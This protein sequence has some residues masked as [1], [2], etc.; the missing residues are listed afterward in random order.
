MNTRKQLT[1]LACLA[2]AISAVAA[3]CESDSNDG[4][5]GGTAGDNGY[6]GTKAVGGSSWGFAGSRPTGGTTAVA[7]N[8]S[9]GGTTATN[10]TG[11][12]TAAGAAGTV[13]IITGGSGPLGAGGTSM[14]GTST[15]TS[16]TGGAATGTTGGTSTVVGGSPSVAGTTAVGGSGGVNTGTTT[17]TAGN[18]GTAGS[19]GAQR[20]SFFVTSDT[21]M[22]GDLGGL[23]GADARCQALAMTVGE[24]AGVWH[25][26][27]SAEGNATSGNVA[28]NAR[29]RI[30]TGPWYNANGRLLADNLIDLHLMSG[31]PE[32]FVDEH[33]MRI[34][35]QWAG[36]PTPLEHD[37][38]T[39]STPNG[40][41]M[42]G[43]TCAG[44]T[45]SSPNLSAQ[46]GHSDGIGPSMSTDPPYDSWNSS[47]ANE[48]CADTAPLG[49]AGRLYC[50]RVN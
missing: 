50:F 33:G 49:G 31:N 30:G 44:W 41:V 11:T 20:M 8:T 37:I 9:T 43:Y 10:V 32:L 48:S 15:R 35:G 47:H 23:V 24:A 29:D 2:I 22:T 46:V 42:V 4:G 45:S 3:G 25:A 6:G 21:N 28:V 16:T 12:G 1:S 19:T 34:N 17:A 38:L 18:A 13:V 40:T 36:S 39:G 27:L 14:G 7:G 5:E 26:Y